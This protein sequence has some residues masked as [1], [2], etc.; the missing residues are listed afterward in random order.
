MEGNP[1]MTSIDPLSLLQVLSKI[2]EKIVDMQVMK[3]LETNNQFLA[4][5]CGFKQKYY[6]E[7]SR[8]FN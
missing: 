4:K 6:T 7:I 5:Q 8:E 1:L 2:L 3:H